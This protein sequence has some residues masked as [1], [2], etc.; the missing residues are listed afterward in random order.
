MSDD[1]TRPRAYLI[2]HSSSDYGNDWHDT[3]SFHAVPVNT[4]TKPYRNMSVPPYKLEYPLD[5]P[6]VT[7]LNPVSELFADAVDYQNYRPF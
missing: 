3:R 2:Q 1:S 7:E 4:I 5:V 6:G